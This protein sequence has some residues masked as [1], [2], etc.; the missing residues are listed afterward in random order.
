[1]PQSIR[2]HAPLP[3]L[4]SVEKIEESLRGLLL[5]GCPHFTKAKRKVQS[6][7]YKM[8]SA[9]VAFCLFYGRK[10]EAFYLLLSGPAARTTRPVSPG[11]MPAGKVCRM[12][13]IDRVHYSN[14]PAT[15]DLRSGLLR[16]GGQIFKCACSG[17]DNR[18]PVAKP[19]SFLDLY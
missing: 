12:V 14:I 10:D 2:G 11:S 15:E 18:C 13:V 6:V 1:M 4:F 3:L 19:Y 5:T 9:Q 8:L 7:C 16:P 17:T